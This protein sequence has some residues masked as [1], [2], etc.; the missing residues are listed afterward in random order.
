MNQHIVLLGDS[1]FDNAAYINSRS[2]VITQL[3][4]KLSSGSQTTLLAVDGSTIRDIDTQLENLPKST[5]HLFI[6]IGGNDALGQA[7]IIG[8]EAESVAEVL[9][10]YDFKS[11]KVEIF[12]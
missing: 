6:S 8:Q 2:D 9:A 11:R 5:T 1:I 3:H 10:N 7:R 12:F 4:S